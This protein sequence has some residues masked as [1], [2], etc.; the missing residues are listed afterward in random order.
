MFATAQKLTAGIVFSIV[1]LEAF[2]AKAEINTYNFE[3]SIT[4]NPAINGTYNGWFSYDDAVPPTTDFGTDFF[5][6]ST[7]NFNFLGTDYTEADAN[8]TPEAAF[9]SD[10]TFLGLAT[11]VGDPSTDAVAFAFEP[12]FFS[13]SEAFFS[14]E[15][16]TYGAGFGDITY[17]L[18]S[19]KGPSIPEPSITL[20][21]MS[22]LIGLGVLR[23]QQQATL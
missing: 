8:A 14:Y 2:P 1:L 15:T 17:S 18:R 12:G 13:L 4:D 7:F 23:R 3:V 6:V 22:G 20:A 9:L 21:L 16:T 10:G 19:S 5:P 11:S